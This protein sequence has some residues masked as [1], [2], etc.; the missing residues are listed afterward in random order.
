MLHSPGQWLTQIS[1]Y[2]STSIK[3]LFSPR[4]FFS[5]TLT[6]GAVNPHA[7]QLPEANKLSAF[8]TI[9]V[10]IATLAAPIH[11]TLLKHSGAEQSMLDMAQLNYQKMVENHSQVTGQYMT[12]IDLN[13]LT[14]IRVIDTPIADTLQL[15]SYL[16]LG[17]TFWL[18]SRG[19]LPAKSVMV[20]FIYAFGACLGLETLIWLT[21][22]II[23][24]SQ[25]QVGQNY[26]I[27]F[28]GTLGSIGAIPRL[29]FLFVLPALIFPKI[30]E[31]TAGQMVKI[32][33][34]AVMGWGLV[35]ITASQAMLSSGL[36]VILP[37]F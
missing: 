34:M 6:G 36:I 3:V 7:H 4:Q 9:A 11:Q 16:A 24:V 8:L 10:L 14:G 12:L 35:G 13:R 27:M 37:S 17:I 15:L 32:T 26:D 2:L 1:E 21:S 28:A 18:F 31:V 25:H 5:H 33:L 22:D 29:L 30:Y 19:R 20:Y 23:M